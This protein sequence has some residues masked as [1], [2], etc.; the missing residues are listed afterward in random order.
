MFRTISRGVHGTAMPPWFALPE[1]DR[2]ALAAHLK[3]LSKEFQEDEAPPAIEVQNPPAPTPARIAHGEQIYL[4]GG[5]ASCHGA[6]G[7]GDGPAA[8]SLVYKSGG[9][10]KPRNLRLGRFHRSTRLVDIYTTIVT[11]LDGTPMASFAKVL[12]PEDLWD[13]ALYVHS[14]TPTFVDGSDGLRCPEAPI[15]LNPDEVVGIRTLMH[16]LHPTN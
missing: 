9:P 11:G 7:R 10:A 2:W 3:T 8:S 4:N 16:S 5:C 15:D 12:S 14:L 13:V 6:T 1:R